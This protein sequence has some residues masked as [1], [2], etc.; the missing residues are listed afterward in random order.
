MCLLSSGGPR[1]S[2]PSTQSR[3]AA[4][5]RAAWLSLALFTGLAG[6]LPRVLLHPGSACRCAELS[7]AA[8]AAG[9]CAATESTPVSC[10]GVQRFTPEES[11]PG[12]CSTPA[13]EQCCAGET[14]APCCSSRVHS[15]LPSWAPPCPCNEGRTKVALAL[16]SPHPLGPV[17]ESTFDSPPLG[18]PGANAHS[19][20]LR[21][22]QRP[23]PEVPPPRM[24]LARAV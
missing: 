16:G 13:A 18:R 4:V 2:S 14:Q 6:G 20:Q 15:D 11:S 10:C 5:V 21:G 8:L 9:C 23:G 7:Q 17:S 3:W 22:R 24:G 1:R 19:T 12:C